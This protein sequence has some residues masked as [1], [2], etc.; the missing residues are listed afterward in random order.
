MKL[1]EFLV[2]YVQEKLLDRLGSYCAKIFAVL[3]IRERSQSQKA[4]DKFQ[5][6][7]QPDNIYIYIYISYIY[8]TTNP[9]IVQSSPHFNY[10]YQCHIEQNN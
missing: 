1:N 8:R 5:T 10:Q 6:F 2:S 4:P 3:I 9:I 7:L